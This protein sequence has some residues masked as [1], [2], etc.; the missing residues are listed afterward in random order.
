[1]QPNNLTALNFEDIKSSIKSYLRTRNEF[2]D[3]DFEGSSLSYLID[4][5]AYN[6][7]Y[8][9]FNAN[10]AMNEAFLPSATVRDNV[11]NVAK[12]LNYVPRSVVASKG[13]LKLDV[14]TS[15][16]AGAY[17]S[18]VTLKKGPVS[19]G[20]N[21]IFNILEDITTTVNT[22]TGLATFD[23][24]MVQEGSV[25]TFQYVVN[26]FASQVYKVPSEDAD[27]STLSVR[28]KPNES[29][30]TSDLYSLTDTI[31]D[32][33]AVTRAYFLSEGED[34][35]YEVK[36][37]DDTA[38]RALKDGEVVIL[39][40]LVC[41]GTEANEISSFS[42]IGT[43]TDNIG[44][45]YAGA[46][47]TLTV[48]EKSQLGSAAE[49][50]ES[51]KYNAPR[52]YSAQYRAVTAQDYALITKKVYSNADSVVAYGG[53]SLTPPI[54][55]KVYIA[56]KTKTGSLLN[57]ATKK[58]IAADLRKYAMASIDP[59]IIDPEEMYLYIKVFGQYDPG[60]ASNTSDIKTNIQNG[61]N[62]WASQ[63]QINNFNSTFRAQAFEKAVTLSDKSI[64]DVSLQLSVLK[65][66]NPN[67]N[68]TNTY[69]IATG[70]DLYDS[71]PSNSDG[72]T[73]KK[74]P[75]LL[76]GPFRT[77]DRPGIDQQFED[78]GF[79]NLRTFYNTGNKKVY[80]NNAAGTVNYST[81]QICFGP[82]NII[83]AGNDVP[84]SG[85]INITDST[86]GSGSVTNPDLLPSGL[87]IPVLFIPANVSTIPAATP[88]TIINVINPE[89]TVV[90]VGTTPPPTIPLNSLTPQTF[91][92]V[93]STIT[94]ADIS[95]N[96]DLTTSSCF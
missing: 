84:P 24:V 62:D 1:M 65:Y 10:M 44:N 89:V 31:T 19:S 11:V 53:D 3:Y 16:T 95:N 74:E 76:S 87:A 73:C 60:T 32:L 51:I 78:D 77:A 17:P 72:T 4:I 70:A 61:I 55:G 85:A 30:T 40:Y 57:D 90:P 46:D 52:Y 41:S 59:V 56:I 13:C 39:E 96:G 63:S 25:V 15:Q 47:V 81:G 23:N 43:I 6:T 28:V 26:T 64:S 92:T 21:Y 33:T 12:L 67:T 37:G 83:G 88:G 27:I 69:C 71:A 93:P 94:V 36:F 66:I 48:K 22:T 50:L 14:Q 2:S 54:Y 58:T 20:G 8:T 7:Y 75:V 80:T 82:I 9:S 86:T 45:N 49:T 5:L 68:Q 91:V 34:M 38:G 42:F 79:G 29:S 18:S 35:R